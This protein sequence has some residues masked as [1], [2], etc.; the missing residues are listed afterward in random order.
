M[1]MF[2]K[3]CWDDVVFLIEDGLFFSYGSLALLQW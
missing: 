2:L 3:C 1:D